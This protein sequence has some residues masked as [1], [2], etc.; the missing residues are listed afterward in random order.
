MEIKKINDEKI[1]CG[2]KVLTEELEHHLT[3][4]Y[5]QIKHKV[6][7]KGFRKGHVPR[8]IFET[9]FGKEELYNNALEKIVQNKYKEALA[10]KTFENMGMPKIVGLEEKNFKEKKDFHFNL[11][12]NLKPKVVLGS[13]LGIKLSKGDLEITKEEINTQIDSLLDS[14][15]KLV[16]KNSNVLENN[17]TA[18]FDFEGFIDD[19]PFEGGSA[20]NFSLE[21]GSKKFVPGF[22]E[23]MIGMKKEETRNITITFPNDYPKSDL[24]NKKAIFKVTLH[25]LKTKVKPELTNELVVSL[26][27]PEIKTVEELQTKVTEE[28]TKQK[29]QQ[30]KR[31]VEKEVLDQ[32]KQNTQLT[33][34]LTL[35]EEEKKDIKNKFQAQLQK[36]KLTL[37]QYQSYL[38][39]TEEKME[40]NWHEEAKNN[41][42]Y[43]LIM[44][45]VALQEKI[46]VN[47]EKI[48]QCYKDLSQMHQMS[49]EQVK[50]N[51][52]LEVLKQNLLLDEAWELV[53]K[54]VVFA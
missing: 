32:I 51:L 36:Q 23:Q 8:K 4:A 6:E 31:R 46:T 45:Q 52:D 21:I 42:E 10:K 40:Q 14:K 12:F 49:L 26:Q 38:G 53:M 39:I 9:R 1:Q 43:Q 22:E 28:L 25:D 47:P 19:K 34:P 15:K 17:D 44:E 5:E 18:I 30:N 35:I 33:I 13:Y 41:L 11:E 20:K 2:F 54:N 24:A 27:Y 16:P 37:E 3:L 29:E 48:E 7:V 50:Q